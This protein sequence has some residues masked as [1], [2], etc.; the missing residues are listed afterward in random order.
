ML[1]EPSLAKQDIPQIK[2]DVSK[3]EDTGVF[4]ED[5]KA[6]WDDFLAS[7]PSVYGSIPVEEPNWILD[8]FQ[9]VTTRFSDVTDDFS[10]SE[11]VQK[12]ARTS[13]PSHKVLN[14]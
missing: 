3:Y 1:I 2:K 8:S 11:K 4:T 7:F 6:N 12:Q 14:S 10:V 9:S 5:D 13:Q